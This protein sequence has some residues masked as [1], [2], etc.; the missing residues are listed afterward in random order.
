MRNPNTTIVD[1]S[2]DDFST[3]LYDA[4]ISTACND[5][6]AGWRENEGNKTLSLWR[7]IEN[8]AGSI[9]TY[10]YSIFGCVYISCEFC[11]LFQRRLLSFPIHFVDKPPQKITEH[12]VF[13]V[14]RIVLLCYKNAFHVPSFVVFVF[15][16]L[17]VCCGPILIIIKICLRGWSMI[18]FRRIHRCSHIFL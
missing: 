10:A 17:C 7:I 3:I 2:K 18:L 4:L 16:L 12:F 15:S 6:M 1:V 9:V 14:L 11:R 8:N 5:T 13:P